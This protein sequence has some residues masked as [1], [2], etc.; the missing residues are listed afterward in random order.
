[1]VIK[2]NVE[3]ACY[4]PVIYRLLL[5]KPIENSNRKHISRTIIMTS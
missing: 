4:H 2:N 5:V 3:A 1:M